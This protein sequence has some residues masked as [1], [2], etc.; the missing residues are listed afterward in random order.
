MARDSRSDKLPNEGTGSKSSEE[1]ENLTGDS[2][3]V[4]GVAVSSGD[5]LFT[6]PPEAVRAHTPGGGSANSEK[7]SLGWA[8][9]GEPPSWPCTCRSC[10]WPHIR[11]HMHAGSRTNNTS[12]GSQVPGP[13]ASL[14]SIAPNSTAHRTH[15]LP[16][17]GLSVLFLSGHHKTSKLTPCEVSREPQR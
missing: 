3:A 1:G 8:C 17:C 11:P 7:S 4:G 5:Q 13:P 12:Q 6:R 15:A 10:P 9:R 2:T 14:L 16:P